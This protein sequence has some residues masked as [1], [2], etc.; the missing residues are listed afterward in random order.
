MKTLLLAAVLAAPFAVAYADGGNDSS[1]LQLAQNLD[2]VL[3]TATRTPQREDDALAA[4]TVITRDEIAQSQ[5][6]DLSDLLRF[7]AGL[8]IGRNG[9]PGQTT[10]L[11]TRGGNSDSTLVLL[12]GVP[13][14]PG[15]AGGA[16]LQNLTPEMIE[17]IEIVKGPRATIY[18]SNAVAGVV[19]II[20]RGGAHSG[21]DVQARGGS[22]GTRDASGQFSYA[23][24]GNELSLL[25]QTGA[26]HGI[27]TCAN[28][29]IDSGNR[30]ST[31]N[32]RGATSA[33]GAR[34]E[35]RFWNTQ[36][37]TQYL[38]SCDPAFGLH[39][40]SENFRN[41]VGEVA[42]S[43]QPLTK[44]Q[45]RLGLSHTLDDIVQQ[46]ANTDGSHDY[47]TTTRPR[48]DW[49]N[50]VD[51]SAAQR[52]SF[53]LTGAREDV[54]ALS[55]GSAIDA[56]YSLYTG[57]VQDEIDA[58]RHH[59]LVAGSY[60]HYSSFGGHGSWNAEYGYDLF[61][62]TRLIAAAGTGFR[63]PNASDLYGFGG[64]PALRP[65]QARNYELGLRQKLGAHQTLDARAFRSDVDDLIILQYSAANNPA[66]DFGFRSINIDR[67]RNQGVE[68]DYRLELAA[69]SARL[70]A[71][72]QNPV[73]QSTHTQLLRRAKQSLSA[74]LTR[75]FG[76]HYVSLAAL[77]SGRRP[78]IDAISG[79]P[80]TD[81][82]YTLLALT[83]GVQLSE[84]FSMQARIDNLLDKHYQTVSGFNQ[85]G[86]GVFVSLR[87]T[88]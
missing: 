40:L 77:A 17:R 70:G 69:W 74:S 36:G 46:Q 11:F 86:T 47:I 8:D 28:S 27:P 16:A 79:S 48:V 12:D 56:G 24:N 23:G 78:D 45:T 33:G 59:A 85:P 1:P 73:D 71:I 10:S 32:L 54:R 84:R 37:S 67:S 41:H 58:G 60:A 72:S 88:E 87:Y 30:Q 13:V 18:G 68:L 31:V 15:S 82:G 83:G 9:G 3:V 49:H 51:L 34:L 29:T 65:E 62:P 38:D 42:V 80:V 81:G 63:A 35:A 43:G 55:F 6:T 50:I 5:V 14:N 76:A 39:P 2:P 52:L 26:T 7:Q 22:F 64:N 4:V 53:G 75:H 25:A 20:T 57:F 61:A 19:N 21:I 66:V 44:W